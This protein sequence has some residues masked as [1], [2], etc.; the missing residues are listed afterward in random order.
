MELIYAWIGKFR[1]FNNQSIHFTDKFKVNYNQAEN[2]IGISRNNDYISLYPDHI[3]NMN[4]VVGRNA[5]GKTNLLDL[6]GRRWADRNKNNEEY[7]IKYKRKDENN[8]NSILNPII[9]IEEIIEH[10]SYFQIF[11]LGKENGKYLYC[12]EGNI[13]RNYKE[14]FECH[15]NS[16]NQ[17]YFK[18]KH[19]F[20]LICHCNN[21][22]LVYQRYLDQKEREKYGIISLRDNLNLHYYDTSS[23][24]TDDESKIMIPRRVGM[25]K[26]DS[27]K[28]QIEMLYNQF[29]IDERELF[30]D[31]RY[32][33]TI[34]YDDHYLN[35]FLSENNNGVTKEYSHQRDKIKYILDS[36]VCYFYNNLEESDKVNVNPLLNDLIDQRWIT[37]SQNPAFKDKY[38]KVVERIAKNIIGS[39][40]NNQD[41]RDAS[42]KLIEKLIDIGLSMNGGII[43]LNEEFGDPNNLYNI[44]FNRGSF[45]IEL[46]KSTNIDQVYQVISRTYDMAFESDL[47]EKLRPFHNFFD[48]SSITK[49]SDGEQA[50][51]KFYASLYEQITSFTQEKKKY[52]LL[53]DE[54]ESRMHPELARNFV[55]DLIKFLNDLGKKEKK[56]FQIIISTHSPFILSDSLP[57]NTIYLE[58]DDEG[59]CEVSKRAIRTFASNIHELFMESFFMTS[60]IGEYATTQIKEVIAGLNSPQIDISSK[61]IEKWQYIIDSIGEPI[62]KNKLQR[63]F[64]DRFSEENF[65][66]SRP[67]KIDHSRGYEIEESISLLEGQIKQLRNHINVLKDRRRYD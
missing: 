31:E 60:T 46:N 50:Y 9:G 66:E 44:K 12:F 32:T 10:Y 59:N 33:L 1:N 11:Y 23:T 2:K 43:M 35:E 3:E 37:D 34:S 22:K 19:W 63:L 16:I 57:G 27:L 29:S 41:I 54:P 7:D 61:D 30:K 36:H 13:L 20:S 51:L 39:E 24:N 42:E 48:T 58:K 64:D 56:F 25:F 49:L 47:S 28:S 6:I 67:R 45:S 8:D 18:E 65:V 52:V 55:S 62:V 26:S 4:V 15:G 21:E 40:K 53:L 14:L 5:V 17:E 38:L